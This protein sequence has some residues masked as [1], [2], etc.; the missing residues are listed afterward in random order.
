MPLSFC[1]EARH[2]VASASFRN[3]NSDNAACFCIAHGNELNMLQY[4]S[5]MS[6]EAVWS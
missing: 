6:V 4:C 3:L 2:L 1:L 5:R